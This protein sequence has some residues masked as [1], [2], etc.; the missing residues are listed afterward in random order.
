MTSFF[1]PC[2]N[3]HR[4]ERMPFLVSAFL[5]P[6]VP[7]LLYCFPAS[8]WFLYIFVCACGVRWFYYPSQ[9]RAEPSERWTKRFSYLDERATYTILL[10]FSWSSEP[11]DFLI[12]TD[13]SDF[14]ILWGSQRESR[15]S[16]GIDFRAVR[17]RSRIRQEREWLWGH[18]WG[19]RPEPLLS[20]SWF[21]MSLINWSGSRFEC[22]IYSNK[23]PRRKVR[24][25]LNTFI[26]TSPSMPS[27]SPCDAMSYA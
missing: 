3:V 10:S 26:S 20:Y 5:Y 16:D 2:W 17:R 15:L 19:L 9:W 12:L 23:I 1:V 4:A 27:I 21:V 6:A 8:R 14:N 25:V 13:Q 11:Y 24:A 7:I 22:P 18:F